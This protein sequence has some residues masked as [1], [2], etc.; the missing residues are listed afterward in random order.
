[1]SG[2]KACWIPSG[3]SGGAHAVAVKSTG[4]PDLIVSNVILNLVDNASSK[5]G[6]TVPDNSIKSTE[7]EH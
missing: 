1:M 4:L 5:A 6:N 7:V 3:S 2:P